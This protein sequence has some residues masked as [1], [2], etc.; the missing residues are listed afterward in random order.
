M[1]K[2]VL[3]TATGLAIQ[4]ILGIAIAES[5]SSSS[6]GDATALEEITVTAQRRTESL[7]R[8]PIAVEVLKPDDLEKQAIVSESDLQ[9][10]VPGLLVR[11][12]ATS[13]ALNYSIRGQTVDVNSSSQSSVLPYF[14]EVQVGGGSSKGGASA[15]SFYDLESV[16]VLKGPQGTLFGRNST[17]GAVLFQTA[18]P[19]DEFGGYLS[20]WFGNYKEVK[21]EGAIN[22][23]I[24][25]DKLLLRISGFYESRDGYQENLLNGARLGNVDSRSG[26]ISLTFKPTDGFRN[27]L[28]IDYSKQGGN[29]IEIVGIDT[30]A[31]SSG[32]GFVPGS[33]LYSPLVD[34]AFGAGSWAAFLA[35]HPGLNPAGLSAAVAQQA[36]TRDPLHVRLDSPDYHRSE[37][38]I[39]T[40]TSALDLNADTKIRAIIGYGHVIYANAYEYDGTE[41]PLDNLA[42]QGVAGSLH[43]YSGELQL[44]GTTLA[45]RLKYVTG[46]Y[47]S[48]EKEITRAT[49]AILDLSP[50]TGPIIQL[51]QGSVES[52]DY[53]AYA[54]GTYDLSEVTSLQGLGFTLGG[55]YSRD[56][57]SNLHFAKDAF[58]AGGAPPG[59]T[60][61][62]PLSDT[63]NQFSWTIGL[64]E[65]VNSNLMVYAA[66]RRSFR[67]GGFNFYAPPLP[68]FG[69]VGGSEFHP[70]Q[71]TDGELGVKYNGSVSGIP[72]RLN[73]DVYKMWIDNVQRSDFVSVFG[74][75]AGITVNVPQAQV[76]GF[77]ADA[78]LLPTHW[79]RLG[80]SASYT[81]AKF[82]KN[83]V[84]VLGNA[85]VAFGPY[86]DS[87]KWSTTLFGELTAPLS[88]QVHGSLRAEIY[89]Q[90]SFF[91][92]ST[93]NTLNPGAEL[94]GY[95][96]VNLRASIDGFAKGWTISAYVK[97]ATN[98]L[99]DVGGVAYKSL[100]SVNTVLPGAPRTY[101]IEARYR[102]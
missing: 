14:N 89:N 5:V 54:Q 52:K 31:P 49:T 46:L 38:T 102:F 94:P 61:K 35:K 96:L 1:G 36:N 84:S 58:I 19:T 25:S 74:A 97:N 76:S 32:K 30:F 75:L 88:A 24:V 7:S 62:N 66:S 53:A 9:A 15:T 91:Y 43:Q 11:A 4:A 41:F 33:F 82:T 23:P 81:D 85:P 16:Q 27:D 93:A 69:D 101:M 48:D 70:E 56:E 90:T 59:A 68:G 20:S 51:N 37:N 78:E 3:A 80:A 95:T 60:F 50:V 18:K 22:L 40:N 86:P 77:E 2:L 67:S 12:G 42:P 87:P 47:L 8:T 29:N 55:R 73:A 98:K 92:S 100:L 64:Q 71:A 79:L 28:V 63:F 21:V 72:L 39:V 26:R 45:S 83:Q 99:Y 17:G 57:V 65:Q 10:A 13:N 44:Q 6:A 34:S